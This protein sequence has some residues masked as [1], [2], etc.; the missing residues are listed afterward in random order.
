MIVDLAALPA[1]AEERRWPRGA[2]LIAAG[3][4]EHACFIL[5]GSVRVSAR[6]QTRTALPRDAV[7]LLELLADDPDGLEAVAESDTRVLSISRQVLLDFL[8][9]S[10]AA[11]LDTLRVLARRVVDVAG[12]GPMFTWPGTPRPRLT[13]PGAPLSYA[14]KLLC[15]HAALP[16]A[17][18]HLTATTQVARACRERRVRAGEELWRTGEPAARGLILVAG[19]VE[20]RPPAGRTFRAKGGEPL[21]GLEVIARVPRWYHAVAATDLVALELDRADMLDILEDH[22]ELAIDMMRGFAAAVL[23]FERLA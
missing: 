22:I 13:P 9:A 10:P 17:P 18:R 23:R 14:D 16:H 15:V 11:A 19:E 6:G 20:C 8:A 1:L 7:G 5:D 2:A 12:T 4:V 21:G 3:R